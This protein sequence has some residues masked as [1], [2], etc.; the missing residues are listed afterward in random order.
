[1]F[2]CKMISNSL[3]TKEESKNQFMYLLSY[4]N[5]TFSSYKNAIDG[6]LRVA[7]EEGPRKLFSGAS[8]A[9]TRAVFMTI[10]QLSFYDLVKAKLLAAGFKDNLTTHLM[11]SATAGYLLYLH[12]HVPLIRKFS[13]SQINIV[14]L[15]QL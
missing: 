7:R 9:S 15:Q 14:P 2:E 1:M 10:G 3:W 6:L 4:T 5:N 8:T 13:Y 12:T 11:A